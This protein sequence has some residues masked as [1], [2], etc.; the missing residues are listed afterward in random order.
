MESKVI[1]IERT[2]RTGPKTNGK[3]RASI[4]KFF[5][6]IKTRML[7]YASIDK[8]NS[9]RKIFTSMRIVVSAQQN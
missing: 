8:N 5:N 9:G 4:V 7:S 2:R 3:K 1:T 6:Y